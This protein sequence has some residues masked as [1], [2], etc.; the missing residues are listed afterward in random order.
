MAIFP[1]QTGQCA[2]VMVFMVPPGEVFE[3]HPENVPPG[4]REGSARLEDRGLLEEAPDPGAESGGPPRKY[5]RLSVLGREV[6]EAESARLSALVAHARR[7]DLL[8]A[9]DSAAGAS[10]EARP[11]SLP[12]G[13][14]AAPDGVSWPGGRRVVPRVVADVL[15]QGA[16]L[17][18]SLT[19][20]LR[21]ARVDPMSTLRG[22]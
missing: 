9:P 11:A 8:P 19:P 4:G 18:A 1:G 20:S 3:N 14:A 15:R 7:F 12:R 13:S 17:A 2:T 21:A 5:Y 10:C 6:L 22:D 16:G